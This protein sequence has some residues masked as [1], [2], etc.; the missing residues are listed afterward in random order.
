[1]TWKNSGKP[2]I[3]TS[4]NEGIKVKAKFQTIVKSWIKYKDRP[5]FSVLDK[6]LK[7]YYII[8]RMD[9]NQI[10]ENYKK[11]QE[12]KDQTHN[13]SLPN[14]FERKITRPNRAVHSQKESNEKNIN[15]GLNQYNIEKFRLKKEVSKKEDNAKNL[16][17]RET[18]MARYALKIT[19]DRM[20]Q[21]L[22]KFNQ[23]QLENA[24]GSVL[25]A[26]HNKDQEENTDRQPS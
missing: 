18:F 19:E 21:L 13:R 16:K 1:M 11:E 8:E 3:V 20:L 10:E 15:A 14:P 25:F 24:F 2:T 22:R 9:N 17:A 5:E 23:I 26:Y 7:L 4:F 12:L 6:K